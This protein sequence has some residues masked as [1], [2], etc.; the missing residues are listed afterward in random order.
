MYIDRSVSFCFFFFFLTEYH[1]N[2]FNARSYSN[3]ET[4][5]FLI[6]TKQHVVI[7]RFRDKYLYP[8]FFASNEIVF[9]QIIF[10]LF[11]IF[12]RIFVE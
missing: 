10:S 5:N 3:I 4:K 7:S 2:F 8:I 11:P 6:E 1:I 9:E 12:V